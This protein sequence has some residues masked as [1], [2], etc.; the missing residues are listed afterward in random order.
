[1]QTRYPIQIPPQA[2]S[3]EQEEL[4]AKNRQMSELETEYVS[5]QIEYSTLTG[6][7]AAFRNRYLLRVGTLY[8]QL[9]AVRAELFAQLAKLSP[10]DD[11]AKSAADRAR[12]QADETAQELNGADEEN[13]ITF[14]PSLELKQLYRQAAKLI[15]PDRAQNDEDRILR[16]GLMAEINKAYE[17]G[18]AD[19]IAE[20]TEKYRDRLLPDESDDIGT[21]LVRVI[22]LLAKTRIHIESLDKTI[23]EL[24]ASE[25]YTLKAD[26]ESQEAL[27]G[28]PL[29]R[30]ADKLRQDIHAEETRLR[31]L[32][33]ETTPPV[34]GEPPPKQKGG[35]GDSPRDS[36][37]TAGTGDIGDHSDGHS[38]PTQR[39]EMVKTD[40]EAVIADMLFGQGMDYH[41]EYPLEGKKRPGIRRTSFLFFDA[42]KRPVLWQHLNS[43]A[44]AEPRARWATK[45]EWL[46]ANGF[47]ENVNLFITRDLKD[48]NIDKLGIEKLTKIIKTRL[49]L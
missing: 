19:A 29:G 27:G 20:L 44:D 7:I 17:S 23:A 42:N 9:D 8:T 16:N 18:D 49:M 1:M 14:S 34:A 36:V 31:D 11:V 35:R 37:T 15:H 4:D 5:K 47:A 3:P 38:F 41:Y 26:V 40:S 6:E 24:R 13:P 2:A 48:R 39:G 12:I 22:R 43:L 32:F 25:W 45:L 10:D 46:E 33:S 28:D 21:R 30:L